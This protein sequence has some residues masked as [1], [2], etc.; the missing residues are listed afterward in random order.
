MRPTGLMSH[1][2]PATSENHFARLQPAAFWLATHGPESPS[3]LDDQGQCSSLPS[4]FPAPNDLDPKLIQLYELLRGGI[5]AKISPN[6]TIN[7]P[8]LRCLISSYAVWPDVLTMNLVMSHAECW[9]IQLYEVVPP[10]PLWNRSV[11]REP[12]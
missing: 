5:L 7:P 9:I 8:N 2:H 3:L 12:F 10:A 1:G 4:A 11:P 6:S